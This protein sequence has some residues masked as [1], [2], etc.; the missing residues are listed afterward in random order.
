LLIGEQA[1]LIMGASEREWRR[2]Q[3]LAVCVSGGARL[4][5]F[6]QKAPI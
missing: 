3:E 6:F 5:A 2:R 4:V 1:H